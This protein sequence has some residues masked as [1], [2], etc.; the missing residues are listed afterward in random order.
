MYVRSSIDTF[1]YRFFP[2]DDSREA[3]S[4]WWQPQ[5][6]EPRDV[7]WK[8]PENVVATK[9]V[10]NPALTALLQE[11]RQ[12]ARM[13]QPLHCVLRIIIVLL[14]R[15]FCGARCNLCCCLA[16]HISS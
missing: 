5:E 10:Q 9:Q 3:D 14:Q 16:C 13:G 4:G 8:A 2:F 11:R 6:P 12:L 7:H 15:L 1:R